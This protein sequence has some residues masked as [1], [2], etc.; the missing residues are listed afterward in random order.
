MPQLGNLT[1]R[2]SRKIGDEE[3]RPIE[4]TMWVCY[5][6]LW[7]TLYMLTS[8][9]LLTIVLTKGPIATIV[10]FSIFFIFKVIGLG[11]VVWKFQSIEDAIF[12]SIYKLVSFTGI[13]KGVTLIIISSLILCVVVYIQYDFM[14]NPLDVIGLK[15]TILYVANDDFMSFDDLANAFT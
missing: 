13:L 1:K 15:D 6:I 9:W 8:S 4:I 11:F 7:L 14:T 12:L 5:A 10:K 3:I 2:T